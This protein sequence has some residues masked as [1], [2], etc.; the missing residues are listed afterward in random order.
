MSGGSLD[1]LPGRLADELFGGCMNCDYGEDGWK[2]ASQARA[3]NPLKDKELSE[4]CWDMLCLLHSLEWYDSGDTANY[5]YQ[6][7]V[8]HFKE[9]WFKR[10]EEDKINAYKEDL[11][12]YYL[13]LKEELE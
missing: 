5:T 6:A 4:M 10:T 7:D 12:L 11:Y 8:D 3:Q 13:K 1:Y 9:K 2:Q